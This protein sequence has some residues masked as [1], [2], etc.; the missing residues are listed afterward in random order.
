MITIFKTIKIDEKLLSKTESLFFL[1]LCLTGILPLLFSKYYVTLD[2]AAHLYNANLIKELITGNH[3]EISNLFTINSFPVPN[4]I[5]HFIMALS[6]LILPAFLAEKLLFSIY[7]ILTPIFFRKFILH[8]Y[9]Q[10]KAFTYLI[11]LFVHNHMLYFGFI[12]MSIGIM[13][14]FITSYYFAKYCIDIKIKSIFVLSLLL[15]AIYFSHVIIFLVSLLTLTV[16]ILLKAQIKMDDSNIKLLN[17]KDLYNRTVVLLIAALPGIILAVIYLITIDSIEKGS[18]PDLNQLLNY[19]VDIRP[20]LTLCYCDS[21][22]N[23]SHVLLSLFGVLILSSIYMLIKNKVSCREGQL[24]IKIPSKNSSLWFAVWFV[25]LFLF[26]ILPNSI[27]LTERLIL[28]FYLFFIIWLASLQYPKILNIF[29]LAVIILLH[30]SFTIKHFEPMRDLSKDAEKI[31]SVSKKI[32]EDSIVLTFNYSN[33]W[34]HSHISGY[35]GSNKPIAILENYEAALKW[36]P[37][38]WNMKVYQIDKLNG[39]GVDNKVIASEYYVNESDTTC[40]SIKYTNNRIKPIPYVLILGKLIDANNVVK[41]ILQNHYNIIEN[42]GFC[43]LY[44]IKGS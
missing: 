25:F 38:L 44:R 5:G 40:F 35:L 39:P 34:L 1:L 12:N 41:S 43:T 29:S 24:S 19:L 20:L 28:L 42:N 33:N 14:L 32:K 23:L 6:N 9:P 13:F 2:G 11:I 10:N 8:F 37:V 3:S 4:W 36:F 18:R 7:F 15:L 21:W 22:S 16:V 17:I 26:L 31:V 27:L 30:V